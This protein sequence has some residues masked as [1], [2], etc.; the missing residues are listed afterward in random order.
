MAMRTRSVKL[1]DAPPQAS[2][3]GFTLLE[4]LVAIAIFAIVGTMAMVGYNELVSQSERIEMGA[5]RTRAVQSTIMRMSQDFATLEPRPVR[6]SMGQA[7][8]PA[9][10]AAPSTDELLEL[11][12]SGWSNPAG[13]P[14]PTLQRV[15]YRLDE[16]KLYRDYWPVLDRTMNVEPISVMLLDEVK[17]IS[18]RYMGQDREWKEQW[19]PLGYSGPN[20][21][22]VLPLAVEINIELNDWGKLQRVV[23]VSG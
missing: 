19:P 22:V 23:E 18:I 10:R 9:L 14:R 6:Q 20:A 7:M 17:A 12:H 15:S 4:I 21:T 5:G 11:T 1:I 16:G 13:V 8:D 2:C 3:R